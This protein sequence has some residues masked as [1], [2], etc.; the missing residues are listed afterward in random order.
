MGKVE[1]KASWTG[2][3]SGAGSEELCVCERQKERERETGSQV[4]VYSNTS[5][6]DT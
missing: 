1:E 6:S 5:Y 3:E 2:N 4:N